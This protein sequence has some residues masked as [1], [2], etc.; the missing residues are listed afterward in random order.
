M[1]QGKGW[2]DSCRQDEGKQLNRQKSMSNAHCD[3]AATLMLHAILMQHATLMLRQE[4]SMKTMTIGSTLP[5]VGHAD[6]TEAL[7]DEVKARAGDQYRN[8]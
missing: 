2:G 4:A 5:C 1:G 6:T 7:K 8:N 3:A